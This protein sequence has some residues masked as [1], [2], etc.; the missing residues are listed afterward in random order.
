MSKHD[1]KIR[2]QHMLDYAQEAYAFGQKR[3]RADLDSDRLLDLGLLHLI[4][5]IGE[6]ANYLTSEEQA[7]YSEIPWP[8][9]VGMRNR[10]VHGYDMVD[11]DILWITVTEDLPP[12]IAALEKI[13]SEQS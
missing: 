1:I 5:L 12:L 4:T 6:A 3:S 13:L 7:R 8:E 9:I 2:L 10:L 11:Y